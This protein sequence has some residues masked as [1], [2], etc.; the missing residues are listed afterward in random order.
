M[1]KNLKKTIIVSLFSLIA[2]TALTS[3]ASDEENLSNST[4]QKIGT[5]FNSLESV[6]SAANGGG[7]KDAGIA[8]IAAGCQTGIDYIP[9][10]NLYNDLK[11]EYSIDLNVPFA[12]EFVSNKLQSLGSRAKSSLC[13]LM[14]GQKL[15][16]YDLNETLKN[17]A[18]TEI[19]P[20]LMMASVSKANASGLP[21]LTRLEV[22]MGI[23]D[24]DFVSSVTTVQPLW[25]DE[26]NQHHI[27]TQLSYY[28]APDVTDDN[29]YKNKHDTLNAG[30]AYRYLTPDEEMLYG[31]NVF[32]DHAPKRN[33]NRMSFG[34]DARTS[35]LG[36]AANR[37]F[38]LSDWKSLDLYYEDRAA[39]GWDAQVDGQI[40]ELPSW[41]L[42]LKGY[43]WDE[44]DDGE[45]LYGALANVEFSPVPAFAI[46]AGVRD[47]SQ[48]NPS[49]EFAIQFSHKFNES[50]DLQWKRRTELTP[51]KDYVYKKV[52]RENIIRTTSRYK[53]TA[54]LTVIETSGANFSVQQDVGN[55][56][57]STGET[58]K[59][60]VT[61]TTANTVGA[62][63]RLRFAQGAIL[64]L[65]QNTQV[66]IVPDLI[67]LV[68]GS[69]QY[70]SDGVIKNI[71]IP[72]GTIVLHG[73]DID[74]V[75][76]GTNSTARV[77]D[78]QISFTGTV[79]G[80]ATLN[81]SEMGQS[82]AGVIGTVAQGSGTYNTHEDAITSQIDLVAQPLEGDKVTPYP[83][84]SP[85]IADEQTNVG[86]QLV[87]G[88]KY[89][90][91]VNVTGTP[92]LNFTI[93]GFNRTAT[94]ISGSGTDDL[95]FGYT[96]QAADGGA[97][98]LQVTASDINGATITG[99]G[100]KL[101][102]FNVVNTTLNFSGSVNDVVPPSGYTVA[103]TSDP[104]NIANVSAGAF[105]IS[106]AEAG[107]TYNYTITTS[108]DATTLAGSGTVAS[109]SHAV[110]GLNL[111]TI[112]DGTLTI[113][114]TLTDTS[115][116]TGSAVTDT[117]VKDVVAPTIVSV[118]PPASATYS[119]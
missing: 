45:D 67:T 2:F 4:Q 102:I 97:T 96:I 3:Y 101:A 33:H 38:P 94:Y 8:A 51:V 19:F 17:T 114:V 11:D 106:S 90:E 21:F 71:N 76:N 103:F 1:F 62:Y 70:V 116:N 42:S 48:S 118:T 5:L 26:H 40:P 82:V 41:R 59:M 49:L 22:E 20:M 57:L 99:N 85:R 55:A 65:G 54:K 43:E 31:A 36:F 108:A 18:R 95:M 47:E 25:E 10:T 88:L 12:G 92:L 86:Q 29:G 63:A 53:D 110:T 14:Q 72:G 16:S 39:A 35:Q 105:T 93:N 83:I 84:Q 61:V 64:T 24:N 69:F 89:N 30:L 79:S 73:T 44:Q 32:F 23:S 77:R 46:R 87:L 74:V 78:G 7:A 117:V 66:T 111:G 52:E 109:A 37:Y 13:A 6:S 113:S 58:L 107:S 115:T 104:V 60:P 81:S 119:P 75:S 80:S 100:G 112:T 9:K 27:F 98:S 50:A 68:T 15:Q 91:V 34:V 56:S 28:K